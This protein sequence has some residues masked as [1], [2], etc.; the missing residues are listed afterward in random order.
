[1]KEKIHSQFEKHF[2][3]NG[4]FYATTTAASY[5]PEPSTRA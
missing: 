1:M 2:G 3:G 4:T 5:S